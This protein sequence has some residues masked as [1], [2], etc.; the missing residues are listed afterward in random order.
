MRPEAISKECLKEKLP[1]ILPKVFFNELLNLESSIPEK[2][3]GD[4]KKKELKIKLVLIVYYREKPENYWS[5][6]EFYLSEKHISDLNVV[7]EMISRRILKELGITSHIGLSAEGIIH[8]IEALRFSHD[9]N[10]GNRKTNS[11]TN[12]TSNKI[13]KKKHKSS[14]TRYFMTEKIRK[15]IEVYGD[16][17]QINEKNKKLKKT[18]RTKQEKIEQ[19]AKRA[20]EMGLE[21]RAKEIQEQE[22]GRDLYEP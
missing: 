21:K 4:I 14:K 15:H 8:A 10:A 13:R 19:D 22:L 3:F 18:R 20:V 16:I 5:D 17:A 6:L 9:I 1:K 12:N 2:I 7:A 11:T